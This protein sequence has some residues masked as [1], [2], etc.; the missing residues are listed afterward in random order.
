VGKWEDE[1]IRREGYCPRPTHGARFVEILINKINVIE[2][3]AIPYSEILSS[4][5]MLKPISC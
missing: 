3:R 1:G 2:N 4:S 5:D